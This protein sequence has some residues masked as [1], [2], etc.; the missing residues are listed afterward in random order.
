[1]KQP[2]SWIL[3]A[4]I[5]L[6]AALASAEAPMAPTPKTGVSAEAARAD[7]KAMFGFVPGFL[8]TMPNAAL[9]GAWEELKTLQ[10]SPQTAL[11]CKLKELIGLAVSAQVPCKYCTFA[12]TEFAKLNAASEAEIGEAIV[13]A[14]LTRHWSTMVQGLQTDL[15]KFKQ[16][17]AALITRMKSAPKNASPLPSGRV[18]DAKAALAEIQQVFGGVPDFFRRFPSEA[19]AGAWQEM[20][21]VELSQST[22]LPDK[23]K[24]LIGVA[25]ASQIPCAYCLAADTEFAKLAGASEREIAEAIAMAALTRHWSTYLNGAQTDETQFKRDV[26][27][28]VKVAK[29]MMAQK[30]EA[31]PAQSMAKASQ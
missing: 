3:S 2:S 19:L 6:S 8:N 24:S 28:L 22:A 21:D 25:V 7:I 18:A 13:M 9:P 31:A 15:P 30:P 26:E 17:I 10:L 20:R 27:R 11:P 23:H 29:R 16:E 1:M 12:H 14:A 5:T 4:V